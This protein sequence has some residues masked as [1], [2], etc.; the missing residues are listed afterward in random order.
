MG[1]TQKTRGPQAPSPAIC[2]LWHR[3]SCLCIPSQLVERSAL[4]CGVFPIT[5]DVDDPGDLPTPPYLSHFIPDWRRFHP[6]RLVDRRRP[7]LRFA[8]CGTGTLACDSPEAEAPRSGDLPTPPYLSHL[9]PGH[10][11]LAWTSEVLWHRHSCLCASICRH[12]QITRCPD[13]QITRSCPPP[14]PVHP[15]S[16]QVIPDWRRFERLW[17]SITR[18]PDHQITRSFG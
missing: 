7:R 2:I 6:K 12:S 1:F 16:S 4:G 10:P 3:H 18:S 8:F 15:T 13:H 14:L 9:I 11:R 17:F 5:R